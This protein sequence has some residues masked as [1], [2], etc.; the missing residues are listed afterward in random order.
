M[1]TIDELHREA[2]RLYPE[3]WDAYEDAP[4]DDWGFADAQRDAFIAGAEWMLS[5]V[6]ED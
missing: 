6:D 4:V 1:R 5:S 2:W 3:S